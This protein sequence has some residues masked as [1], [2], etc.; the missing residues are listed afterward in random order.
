MN[1]DNI[2]LNLNQNLWALLVTLVA[3][4]AAEYYNLCTLYIFGVILSTLVSLSFGVTLI[5]YTIN[6][7]K[8]KMKND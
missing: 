7:W 6:Y 3:V 5:A 4:G 2:K 1:T 8:M